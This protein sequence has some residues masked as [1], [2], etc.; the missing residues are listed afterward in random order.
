VLYFAGYKTIADRYRVA[1]IERAADQVIWCCDEPPGFAPGRRQDLAV[2][3]NVVEAIEA[4]GSGT[5]GRAEIPLEAVDRVIAIGSRRHDERGRRAACASGNQLADAV[6]DEG[7]LRVVPTIE[8]TATCTG[9]AGA[10]RWR[11]TDPVRP[12]GRARRKTG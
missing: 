5:L 7:D 2:V 4:Y 11:R 1:D 12:A 8:S 9:S 10:S 6:H 3:G